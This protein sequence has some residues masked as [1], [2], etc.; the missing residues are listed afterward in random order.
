MVILFHDLDLRDSEFRP[1]PRGMGAAKKWTPSRGATK[2]AATKEVA[3][4]K[5][6]PICLFAMNHAPSAAIAKAFED[7]DVTPAFVSSLKEL[8]HLEKNPDVFCVFVDLALF[9]DTMRLLKSKELKFRTSWVAVAAGTK[10][11]QTNS[12]YSLGFADVLVPPVHPIIFKTR[13]VLFLDRYRR[14]PRSRIARPVVVEASSSS[15]SPLDTGRFGQHQVEVARLEFIKK[16]QPILQRY[17]EL[18]QILTEEQEKQTFLEEASEFQAKATLWTEGQQWQRECRVRTVDE[19]RKHIFF[20][21]PP[22]FD[23]EAFR[24]E[25]IKLK[26]QEI[27][28]SVNLR[29]SRIFFSQHI[30]HVQFGSRGLM[31]QIPRVFYQTQRREHFRL[32]LGRANM[33]NAQLTLPNQ[34]KVQVGLG[35]MS[36]GGVLLYMDSAK[37]KLLQIAHTCP[38][39]KF[40]VY[41]EEVA[42]SARVQWKK[43]SPDGSD[44]QVGLQFMV[45]SPIIQEGLSLFVMEESFEYFL[46]LDKIKP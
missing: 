5:T 31:F 23:L 45:I 21:Y 39:I 36:A 12:L 26:S 1:I 33:L 22:G 6:K 2:R 43:K 28:A 27:F 19:K 41:G 11:S 18:F 3:Q 7:I 37:A 38:E 30:D 4:P 14:S 42:C 40:T 29:R 20:A 8:I 32:E 25:I 44:H 34:E 10:T 35:N 16:T 17:Q 13:A 24:G 46:K 15:L 9:P